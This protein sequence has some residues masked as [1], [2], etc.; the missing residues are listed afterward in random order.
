MDK[1][2]DQKHKLDE[3]IFEVFEVFEVGDGRG[4]KKVCSGQF[5]I[6]C[7]ASTKS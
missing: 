3:R 7:T 5:L 6:V 4:E 2:I 1:L